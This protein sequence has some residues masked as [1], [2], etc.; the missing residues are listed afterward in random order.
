[1][2]LF[3]LILASFVIAACADS[4]EPEIFILKDKVIENIDTVFDKVHK[5]FE[6]K[7]YFVPNEKT[8]FLAE[9]ALA[10]LDKECM[11]QKY[12]EQH[13]LRWINLEYVESHKLE[14]QM[15]EVMFGIGLQCSNKVDVLAEFLFENF[16]TFHIIYKSFVDEPAVRNYTR[17][18]EC[19]NKYAVE[20][21]FLDETVYG[22]KVK[23]SEESSDLCDEFNAIYTAASS[24]GKLGLRQEVRRACAIGIMNHI[25]KALVRTILMLQFDLT[26]DQKKEE[27]EHFVKEVHE[28]IRKVAPCAAQPETKIT[29]FFN[30]PKL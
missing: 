28:I 16:M 14:K 6:P 25:E 9:L 12:K 4:V 22:N 18:I 10:S 23:F 3:L 19:A 21:H 17:Y 8:K 27:R 29:G 26:F 5:A 15:A 20:Q 2:K 7:E 24:V 1:M 11:Y 30:I 13:L